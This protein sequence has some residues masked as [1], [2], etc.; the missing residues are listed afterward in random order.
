VL[1]VKANTLKT[2]TR[3]KDTSPSTHNIPIINNHIIYLAFVLHINL[4]FVANVYV[5]RA[6]IAS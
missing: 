5:M 1:G 3:I 4:M 6:H 2:T